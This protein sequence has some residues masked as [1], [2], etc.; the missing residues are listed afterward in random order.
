MVDSRLLV[1]EQKI[2]GFS[3]S[4][5][6]KI[7]FIAL[8]SSADNTACLHLKILRVRDGEEEEEELQVD[9]T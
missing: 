7:A 6:W 1:R 2:K 9:E 4:K 3:T 8:V 5:H